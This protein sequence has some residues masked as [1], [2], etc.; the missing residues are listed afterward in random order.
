M[1]I[2]T[3][4]FNDISHFYERKIYVSISK[5]KSMYPCAICK[6]NDKCFTTSLSKNEL[7][8]LAKH[9]H[10]KHA[11]RNEA[12][13]HE[14]KNANSVF[15]I[16]HGTVKLEHQN[17]QEQPVIMRIARCGEPLGLEAL[18]SKRQY[19]M[20]AIA[21]ADTKYCSIS[22]SQ[23][24]KIISQNM[25]ACA[26]LMEALQNEQERICNYSILMISGSSETKLAQALLS[27][28]DNDGKVKITKEEIAL[29]TGLTRETV[30]R[31]LSRLNT[32][33]IIKTLQREVLILLRA[34]LEKL[35]HG[36]E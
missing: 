26:K 31:I 20:L 25:S 36:I 22:A 16:V 11:K 19:F 18:L 15:V 2:I 30:S 9:I 5:Q 14:N 24:E 29:M 17:A 1:I 6:V 34:E 27:L 4:D 10:I 32:K 28:S 35:V 3:V 33:K 21:L 12:I 7:A 8:E 13:Y 23:V